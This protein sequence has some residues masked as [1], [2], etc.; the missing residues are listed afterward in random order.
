MS[1]TENTQALE[2]VLAVEGVEAQAEAFAALPRIVRKAIFFQLPAEVRPLARA[3][4][5]AR[6][7]V[8]RG[9]KGSLILSDTALVAARDRIVAKVQ[10]I[11]EKRVPALNTLIGDL[12][13]EIASRGIGSN[14]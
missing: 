11:E 8:S 3:I 12:N 2:S 1:M 10:E 6:R 7:G 4:V 13:A 14:S 5:E 9:D